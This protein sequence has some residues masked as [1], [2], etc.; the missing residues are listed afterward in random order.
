MPR[1]DEMLHFF[2]GVLV[3]PIDGDGIVADDGRAG[4]RFG[5]E[6]PTMYGDPTDEGLL[7]PETFALPTGGASSSPRPDMGIVPAVEGRYD[8]QSFGKGGTGG[9]CSLVPGDS[10]PLLTAS[11]GATGCTLWTDETSLPALVRLNAFIEEVDLGAPAEREVIDVE[12]LDPLC[13]EKA[14]EEEEARFID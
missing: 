8:S 5:V 2:V 4:E 10:S 13:A 11:S 12:S 1:A 7:S 9:I 3:C 6:V 14:V